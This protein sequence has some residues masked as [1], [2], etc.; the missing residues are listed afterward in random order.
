MVLVRFNNNRGMVGFITI[1]CLWKSVYNQSHSVTATCLSLKSQVSLDKSNGVD[2]I[3]YT[4][5]L[6]YHI[7]SGKLTVCYRTW[8]FRGDL[9]T[10]MGDLSRCCLLP[11]GSLF[12]NVMPRDARLG[13][14][15][16]G[17]QNITLW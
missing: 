12:I 17:A 8:P 3:I 2:A 6:K 14:R 11:E 4:Q 1:F 15:T 5:T 10:R 13:I 7:P 16:S 9:P